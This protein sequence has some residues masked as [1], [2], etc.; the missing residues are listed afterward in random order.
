[1]DSNMASRL[2]ITMRIAHIVAIGAV[3]VLGLIA[4]TN[5][6][7]DHWEQ[8]VQQK[9]IRE[10]DE[11]GGLASVFGPLLG[12]VAGSMAGNATLRNDYVFFST[13]ET[14][15]GEERYA[16]VGALNNFYF[17]KHQRPGSPQT[18]QPR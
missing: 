16:A 4:Y 7:M 1:M 14:R 18:Q 11:K 15:L 12:K 9:V 6:K 5:P 10:A 13:Y 17:W 3:P 8:Y 2:A